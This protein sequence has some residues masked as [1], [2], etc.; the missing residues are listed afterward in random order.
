MEPIM[1]TIILF[2]GNFAP[3]GWMTCEGQLLPVNQY[4]ALYSLLGNNYGG[5]PNISF[6]L[7]DLRGAFPTQCT[8]TSGAHPG[9]T[10]SL[11]QVGGAQSF[12]ITA[13]N[14]PPH[15]HNI[16]KGAGTNLTGS[17]S[18]ATIVNVTSNSANAAASPS[19]GSSLS[20][21]NDIGGTGG[22]GIYNTPA[23][24]VPLNGST[25]SS[26]VTN[27]LSFDPTGLTLTPYGSG[28][29]PISNVPN[30]VAMQYI[31]SMDG[32]YPTRP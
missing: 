6:N 4:Q 10:Y 12:S 24:D 21:V 30:F 9:G 5:T 2:A 1:G 32:I 8:N 17:V 15:T 19:I 29:N 7:P 11:G 18:V 25:A 31:I 16:V 20:A 3:K 28:P 27:T 13:N 22:I 26:V 14:L 23:P